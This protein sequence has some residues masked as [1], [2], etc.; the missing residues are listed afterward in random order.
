[1]IDQAVLPTKVACAGE[2]LAF[3][4]L[5]NRALALTARVSNKASQL[6]FPPVPLKINA[7]K[8][9]G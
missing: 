6:F 4:L 2:N 5:A 7:F 3:V 9:E 1:M 8:I